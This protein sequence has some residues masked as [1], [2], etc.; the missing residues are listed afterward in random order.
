MSESDEGVSV[1]ATRQKAGRRLNCCTAAGFIPGSVNPPAGTSW[2]KVI[3][4]SGS[5][6][7]D[8]VSHD[9]ASRA[10][11]DIII[12]RSR[13][14]DPPVTILIAPSSEVLTQPPQCVAVTHTRLRG[15]SPSNVTVHQR[16]LRVGPA[17]VWCNAC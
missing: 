8:K 14:D 17:A 13:A 12:A 7:A 10:F 3:E 9:S 6:R 15:L 2:A 16:P 4:A 11:P 5:G 1:A